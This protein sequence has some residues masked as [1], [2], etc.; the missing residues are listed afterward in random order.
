MDDGDGYDAA[1]TPMGAGLR[2]MSDRLAALGGALEVRSAPGA[3]TTVTGRLP[4]GPLRRPAGTG[5]ATI[6]ADRQ[7]YDNQ[8]LTE[9]YLVKLDGLTG[10]MDPKIAVNS[11]RPRTLRQQDRQGL[12]LSGCAHYDSPRVSDYIR[13]PGP[14]FPASRGSGVRVPLAP[15][16]KTIPARSSKRPLTPVGSR[17][18]PV[19][20]SA[21]V[22]GMA[23]SG[24]LPFRER[25]VRWAHVS[26]LRHPGSRHGAGRSHT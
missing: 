23:R 17:S 10:S 11:R 18:L 13:Q 6:S 5:V 25:T 19:L 7:A 1:R 8:N 2:N 3:G 24:S 14:D 15:P 20:A 22:G 21:L 26:P 16:R 9:T 4:V 12:I